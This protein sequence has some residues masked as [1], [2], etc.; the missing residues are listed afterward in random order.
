M[1]NQV[2]RITYQESTEEEYMYSSTLS[3]TSALDGGAER[4]APAGLPPRLTRYPSYRRL[5]EP[6]V[7]S[8]RVR[9]IL[10]PPGFEPRTVQPV[11]SC[12]SNYPILAP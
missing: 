12:C 7:R 11:A 3:L 8:G 4:H 5:G 1:Q 2:R 9:K 6:Q 10:P